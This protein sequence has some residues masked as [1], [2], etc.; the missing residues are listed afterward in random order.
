M[1][2]LGVLLLAVA[3]CSPAMAAKFVGVRLQWTTPITNTD[4]TPC[5]NLA[6]FMIFYG[7]SPTNLDD[8]VGL[9][10]SV[11]SYTFSG[12][13]AQPWYFAVKSYTNAGAESALSNVVEWSPPATLGQPVRLP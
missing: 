6:G 10:P 3:V 4:G 9:L 11:T 2:R 13:A 1:K 7:T 5:T 12:L 8:I